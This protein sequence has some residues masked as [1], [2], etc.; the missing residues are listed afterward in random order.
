MTQSNTSFPQ[1]SELAHEPPQS[2]DRQST[3]KMKRFL[4]GVEESIILS[5][6]KKIG[7]V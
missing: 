3:P 6:E 1:G 5:A 2:D 7:E 4:K